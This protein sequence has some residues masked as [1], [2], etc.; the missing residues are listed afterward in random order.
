MYKGPRFMD[1]VPGRSDWSEFGSW[2]LP[3]WSYYPQVH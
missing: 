1:Q 3:S 2:P